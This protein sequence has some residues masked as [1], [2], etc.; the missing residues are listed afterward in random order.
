MDINE[1]IKLYKEGSST[2]EI[3]KLAGYKTAK[4]VGDKLKKAGVSLRTSTE[5]KTIAKGYNDNMFE[6]LDCGWK[7]YYLG[8]LL[9]DGW[10][11]HRTLGSNDVLGFSST[12]KDV[13][14]YIS[15][16]TGKSIQVV[17][18][19][20]E[21]E[22]YKKICHQKTEYRIILNSSKIIQDLE[23]LGVV[24]NKS[25]ILTGPKLL[26]SEYKYLRYILRGIIDGDG[27]LGFPSNNNSMYFRIVSA[28]ETFIDWCIEALEIL[29]MSNL[30]K[31]FTTTQMWEVNSAAPQNLAILA[32]CIYQDDMG[33]SRKANKIKNHFNTYTYGRL[34][35]KS[36]TEN[37]LNCGNLLRDQDTNTELGDSVGEANHFESNNS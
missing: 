6:N 26:P 2:G 8:L 25:K 22:I 24:P 30:R 21:K 27:T 32:F 35:K 23:R 12:D 20:P 4:S 9:T 14:E 28:S 34:A 15:E 29:G 31:H 13:V 3:A 18:R 5:S 19:N 37:S 1:M 7:A 10:I 17:N 33:M 36:A 16:C 11:S